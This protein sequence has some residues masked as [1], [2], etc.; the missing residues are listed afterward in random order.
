MDIVGNDINNSA[1][2]LLYEHR[3]IFVFLAAALEGT[4]IMV[5]SGVLF[6]LGYFNFWPLFTVLVVGYF[7]NGIFWYLLGRLGGHHLVEKFIKKFK[8]GR[9][10]MEKLEEYFS[11]HAE[12]TLF[13]TRITYGIGM[14]A[15]MIAGSL[16]MKWK[17]F[18]AINMVA[19]AVW[20]IGMSAL[21]YG[22]GAGL[23]LLK[24]VTKGITTGIIVIIFLLIIL[25]SVSFV[26]W[27]RYF[28]KTRFVKDLEN[29]DSLVLSS[30]G[31]FIR[32][33]FHSESK[34]YKNEN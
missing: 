17:K 24:N 33:A 16:R 19:A 27:M 2:Q 14:F 5:L 31:G 3:Y 30:I 12:K 25:I 9:R 10:G 20:V 13:L 22:F 34:K 8:T 23:G 28:A 6:K 11:N 1:L 21:G 29:H 26:A 4:F 15:F 18:T 32:K 7:L